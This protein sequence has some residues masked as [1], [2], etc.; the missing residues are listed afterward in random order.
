MDDFAIARALHLLAVVLWVGGVGFVTT[1]VTPALRTAHPP[2][3]RLAAFHR[4]ERQFVAQARFWVTLAGASGIWMVWRGDLWARFHDLHFWW[5]H[6]MFAMWLLFMTMLFVVE[7]FVLHR[8]FAASATPERDFD[9]IEIMHRV[10]LTL[11]LVTILAAALGS[12]G[13]L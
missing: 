1:V 6:L 13:M 3:E 4:F 11:L 9:R 5:M 8:A 12:R 10:V 2:A 7:P